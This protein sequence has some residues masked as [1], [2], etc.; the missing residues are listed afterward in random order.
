MLLSTWGFAMHICIVGVGAIG[1]WLAVRLSRSNS[2]EL[3]CL[4]KAEALERLRI[5]GLRLTEIHEGVE[6]T[7][8][9]V[10]HF[11]SDISKE[12]LHPDWIILATKST[13]LA[14]VIPSI[15][16]LIGP[17]TH[18]LSAMNGVPWWFMSQGDSPF[19]DRVIE[20]VN[21]GG[22]FQSMI[23]LEHW[24]GAVVHASCSSSHSGVAC[25]HFGDDL[26]IGEPNR[27]ETPRVRELQA[28]LS[29]VG[30]NTK[31]STHIQYDIWYK[32]WGNMTMNPVSVLT[33][34]TTNKI[35]KDELVLKFV[36]DIMLEA[37]EIGYAL[38]IN[39]EQSPN[40]RHAVTAKLG[41]FKSSML[42]D[43]ES[44]RPLEL[45][46]LVSS[47]QELGRWVG[48]PTPYIDALLGLT[49]L[50][51]AVLGL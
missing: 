12:T 38:G 49:R 39:I 26:I 28:I 36:S 9:I 31:V 47:V 24:V 44:H 37:R 16:A 25:H 7:Q 11:F 41:S 40:E 29:S 20:S 6:R 22:R 43:L 15:Q 48:V 5:E 18:V 35:L 32:L 51:A 46:A 3:S 2:V 21:P 34:A 27:M 45:N 42:Q 13:A 23:G 14:S 30:F 33:G 4:V 19:K 8:C 17:Q 10:P 50:K 1:T